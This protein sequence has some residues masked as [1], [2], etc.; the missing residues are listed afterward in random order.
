MPA[1]PAAPFLNALH[2][3]TVSL[4]DKSSLRTTLTDILKTL[5]IFFCNLIIALPQSL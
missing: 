5:E 1:C 4:A 3:I 2:D